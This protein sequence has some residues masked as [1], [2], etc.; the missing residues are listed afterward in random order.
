MERLGKIAKYVRVVGVETE[1]G[2]KHVSN[3][4]LIALPLYGVFGEI[5]LTWRVKCKLIKDVTAA[6]NSV[7]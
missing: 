6:G 5:S 7:I 1:I 2:M 3:S 4:N